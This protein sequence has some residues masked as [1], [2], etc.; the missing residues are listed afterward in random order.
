MQYLYIIQC[1]QY[2]KIGVANDVESRLA[3]LST[4]NPFPLEVKVIYEFENA[5][6][7]ERA[8]HQKLKDKRIRGEWFELSYDETIELHKICLILG[9]SA[10][11][12]AGE[13]PNEESIEEAEEIQED[14][15]ENFD[16][17]NF[18]AMFEDG[19]QMEYFSGRRKLSNG[20]V[21]KTEHKYWM[22]MK[23][24]NGKRQRIYGG[25]I[26]TLPHSVEEMRLVFRDGKALETKAEAK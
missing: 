10:F 5:E 14:V 17:W 4:G 21:V 23:F 22:W 26:N 7:V 2:Y 8:I 12:Y 9:G 19:W 20:E 6:I 24:S 16:K 15:L 3:Q 1:Q 13:N 18:S 11:E 25:N